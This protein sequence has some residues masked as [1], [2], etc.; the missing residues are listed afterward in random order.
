[1]L[2]I[3]WKKREIAPE[4]QF[5]LLTTI[6]SYLMLDFYVKT[7]IRVSLRDRW[8]FE[9]TEIEITRVD[10]NLYGQNYASGGHQQEI[11]AAS[12]EYL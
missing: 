7:R 8:L 6:F 10:C 5:L 12:R 1:M 3:L 11:T 2:K 4:E 9:I